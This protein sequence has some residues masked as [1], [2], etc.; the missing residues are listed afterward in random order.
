MYKNK[1]E[2]YIIFNSVFK[3]FILFFLTTMFYC[4]LHSWDNIRHQRL[5]KHGNSVTC[6]VKTRKNKKFK[7]SVPCH[8]QCPMLVNEFILYKMLN[9]ECL[10][11][12]QDFFLRIILLNVLFIVRYTFQTWNTYYNS[13]FLK[14]FHSPASYKT[15]CVTSVKLADACLWFPRGLYAQTRS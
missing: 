3:K 13:L 6:K 12:Y 5:V 1:P 4:L 11:P 15:D 8:L 14:K 2:S 9:F 10:I 7:N